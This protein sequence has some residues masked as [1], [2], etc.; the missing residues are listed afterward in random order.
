MRNSSK[1]TPWF[2]RFAPGAILRKSGIIAVLAITCIVTSLTPVQTKAAIFT[3]DM[4]TSWAVGEGLTAAKNALLAA[5]GGTNKASLARLSPTAKAVANTAYWLSNSY[6]YTHKED[7]WNSDT[8][9]WKGNWTTTTENARQL[10]QD[11]NESLSGTNYDGTAMTQAEAKG[12]LFHSKAS[13]THVQIELFTNDYDP[14]PGYANGVPMTATWKMFGSSPEPTE[15]I[16]QRI[17]SFSY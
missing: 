1:K 6:D 3:I 15:S 17:S 10:R 16:G 5:N 2:L 4:I 8:F 11:N 12:H 13:Y 7:E 14:E 9:R